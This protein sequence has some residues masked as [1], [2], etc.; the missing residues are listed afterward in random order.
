MR[1]RVRSR[2]SKWKFVSTPGSNFNCCTTLDK[3]LSVGPPRTFE[4]SDGDYKR[5]GWI[6]ISKIMFRIFLHQ[7]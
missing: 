2:V 6:S 7:T 5:V 4:A 1:F 3:S